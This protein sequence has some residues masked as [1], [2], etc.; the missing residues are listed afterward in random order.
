MF[1]LIFCIL[2]VCFKPRRIIFL[3]QLIPQ[4]N[5]Y[6][7][8]VIVT[9][10]FH[11]YIMITNIFSGILIGVGAITY[12]FY[13]AII[14]KELW[15]GGKIYHSVDELRSFRNVTHVYRCLQVLHREVLPLFGGFLVIVNAFM[16]L[17]TIYVNFVL[18]RYWEMLGPLTKSALFFMDF[19][20]VS[21]YI[22]LLELGCIF[23]LRGVKALQ[24]W[25]GVKWSESMFV[26]RKMR[27]FQRS[28][29][30][31]ILCWGNH[32]IIGRQSIFI[33]GRGVVRGTF[34]ALLTTK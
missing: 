29:Q 30:P 34:R 3:G 6:F 19:T 12:C 5:F 21:F 16:M 11:A 2:L 27:R 25:K 20:L 26:N 13:V 22:N 28:C 4:E 31:I 17:T 15:F 1:L 18:M 8:F 32:F 24:S 14:M 10:L 23:Y 33:Y 9:I 7:P